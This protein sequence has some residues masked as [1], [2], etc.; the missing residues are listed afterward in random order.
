MAL[1][2]KCGKKKSDLKKGCDSKK[3]PKWPH[4]LL[5]VRIIRDV[6][7]FLLPA[8][9]DR[10]MPSMFANGQQSA[11][12]TS[13]HSVLRPGLRRFPVIMLNGAEAAG[14]AR[15]S[16]GP[17]FRAV[18]AHR[19]S[20]PCR[21]LASTRRPREHPGQGRV[22]TYRAQC[23]SKCV[24]ASYAM[25]RYLCTNGLG[26]SSD[27]LTPA[28]SPVPPAVRER[29]GPI[30]LRIRT[31]RSTRQGSGSVDGAAV[32]KKGRHLHAPR[33][34]DPGAGWRISAATARKPATR[35]LNSYDDAVWRHLA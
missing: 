4:T 9:S 27:D 19:L 14:A 6:P 12:S 2:D 17:S 21:I 18:R 13:M 3:R 22:E 16:H 24:G 25:G 11:L 7:G 29:L 32:G 5:W 30:T 1:P 20:S 10:R 8:H 31:E 28:D 33:G 15:R 35:I 34:P 26:K 23:L